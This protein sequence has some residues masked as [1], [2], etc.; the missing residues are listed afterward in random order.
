MFTKKYIATILGILAGVAAVVFG[1]SQMFISHD[2]PT[3]E[4]LNLEDPQE[5]NAYGGPSHPPSVTPP[6]TPPPY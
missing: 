3:I 2:L 5:P 1:I 4:E 6:T